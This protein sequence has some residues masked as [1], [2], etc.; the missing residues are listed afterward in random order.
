M[1]E[2]ILVVKNPEDLKRCFSVIH[3]LRPHLSYEAY[4][5]IYRNAHADERYELVALEKQGEIVAAMGYRITHDFVR[6]K[7][8]YID[9]LVVTEKERSKGF[10]PVL[11][12]YAAE[13][14]KQT[15]CSGLRLC[16]ALENHRG[17][18]FYE[19]NGWKQRAV[20][21]NKKVAIS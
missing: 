11:L 13:R 15:Q 12:E 21:Y 18:K 6:G 7:H 2:K 20:A 1:N 3:E 10:A 8:I 5:E 16:A 9:D 4:A 17:M 14:A 19:K